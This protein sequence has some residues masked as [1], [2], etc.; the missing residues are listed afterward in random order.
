MKSPRMA[1]FGIFS[2]VAF[3]CEQERPLG[4]L[5]GDTGTGGSDAGSETGGVLN[6]GASGSVGAGMTNGGGSRS[7]SGG[8]ANGGSS[9]GGG[10][11]GSGNGGA[12]GGDCFSPDH[13]PERSLDPN[14]TGCACSSDEVDQCVVVPG[15]PGLHVL[16]IGCHDG[17]WTTFEDGACAPGPN[18]AC[19]IENRVFKDGG[20]V[21]GEF[22]CRFCLFCGGG[23][24]ACPVST[25]APP[26]CPAGTAQGSRCRA[27]GF[28]PGGC[29]VME[30]GCFAP[31]EDGD[32][33]E[34]G[35]CSE[36]VCSVGPC[37]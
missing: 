12:T 28:L 35:R 18:G 4:D 21:P 37:I 23:N 27:C 34:W 11:S 2:M 24:G 16:G 3:A 33:C 19:M 6:G 13:M 36:G 25:C 31:C 26:L 10:S 32:S 8:S 1:A 15:G 30:H 17:R 20:P 5:E 7:T 29:D 14:A 22:L 9:E